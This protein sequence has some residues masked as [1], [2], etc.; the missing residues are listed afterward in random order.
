MTAAA[1]TRPPMRPTSPRSSCRKMTDTRSGFWL[2]LS[3]ASARSPSSSRAHRGRHPTIRT[4]DSMFGDCVGIVS[5]LLPIVG[6]LSSTS[7]WSQRTALTT[8]TL[9]PE[10]RPASW[11]GEAAGRL[12][13]RAAAVVV[14]SSPSPRSAT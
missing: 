1:I 4:F 11:T 3:V 6:L 13:A 9:V 12:R 8:F 14:A 10:A 7:E 2:L 5:V